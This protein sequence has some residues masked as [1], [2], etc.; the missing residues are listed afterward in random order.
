M[1]LTEFQVVYWTAWWVATYQDRYAV[2]D[3][4]IRAM[5][6]ALREAGVVLPYQRLRMDKQ[7]TSSEMRENIARDESDKKNSKKG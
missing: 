1:E 7:G 5:M 2:Q 6:R 4:V 3:K